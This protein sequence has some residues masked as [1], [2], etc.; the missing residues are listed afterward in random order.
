[1]TSPILRGDDLEAIVTLLELAAIELTPERGATFT[2]EQLF[3]QVRE[4]GGDE[5]VPTERDLL[6]VL[7]HST[8]LKKLPGRRLRLQ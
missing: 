2:R 5:V 6:I 1:M 7:Q 4:I 8:F 3:E